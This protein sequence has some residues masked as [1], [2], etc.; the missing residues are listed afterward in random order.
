MPK[1]PAVPTIP[2]KP[3]AWKSAVDAIDERDAIAGTVLPADCFSTSN[4][5]LS[6]EAIYRLS[7]GEDT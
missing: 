4:Y 7:L 5:P 3:P 6:P 1:K 2:D